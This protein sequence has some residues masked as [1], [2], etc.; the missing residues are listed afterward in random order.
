MVNHS[1]VRTILDEMWNG[2]ETF[3]CNGNISDFS[4]IYSRLWDNFLPTSMTAKDRH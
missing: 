3:K 4:F 1:K 2:K